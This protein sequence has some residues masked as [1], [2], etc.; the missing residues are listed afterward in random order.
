MSVEKT[1]IWT[2]TYPKEPCAF[3][4]KNVA[5]RISEILIFDKKIGKSAFSTI[6]AV[7]CP[8]CSSGVC[9]WGQRVKCVPLSKR[10]GMKL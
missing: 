10:N 1:G 3:C 4:G 9:E 8:Q 6:V 2:E 7:R 5:I